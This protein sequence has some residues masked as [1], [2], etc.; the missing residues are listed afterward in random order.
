MA[1]YSLINIS[2]SQL[3]RSPQLKRIEDQTH[4]V[5]TDE[6]YVEEILKWCPSMKDIGLVNRTFSKV[7]SKIRQ[8]RSRLII[9]DSK[10]VSFIKFY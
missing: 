9:Q 5:F 8:N 6:K 4:P 2:L 10:T 1:N 3:P 7:A